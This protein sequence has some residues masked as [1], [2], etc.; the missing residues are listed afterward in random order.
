MK[1]YFRKVMFDPFMGADGTVAAAAEGN[2]DQRSSRSPMVV[3]I[4][5]REGPKQIFFFWKCTENKLCTG[6]Y[7]NIKY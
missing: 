2:E 1:S 5:K 4:Q 7:V 3:V 6:N